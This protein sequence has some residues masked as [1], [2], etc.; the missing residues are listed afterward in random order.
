MNV[1]DFREVQ[2]QNHQ[3]EFKIQKFQKGQPLSNSL[4]AVLQELSRD[5]SLAKQIPD[6]D[7]DSEQRL[8]GFKEVDVYSII[9]KD[10][11]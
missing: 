6:F 10:I 9:L 2:L 8:S 1:N 11:F 3:S 7:I 4:P 5:P